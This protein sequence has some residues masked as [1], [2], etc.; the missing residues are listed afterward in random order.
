MGVSTGPMFADAT[1]EMSPVW[2]YIVGYDE[3]VGTLRLPI[4]RL[5]F[6]I[7][8]GGDN[9]L[10]LASD[11]A[12]SR[13]HCVIRALGAVLEIEDLGSSN[14]TQLNGRLISGKTL[15]PL[16][17][18]VVVGSTHLAVV[19]LTDAESGADSQGLTAA[20]YAVD[21]TSSGLIVPSASA[22]SERTEAL[23]VV[24]IVGSTLLLQQ[25]EL[26]V[27]QGALAVGQMLGRA[28]GPE[29]D[30][31]LQ[32]TGDGYLAC[33][34]TADRALA[35]AESVGSAASRHLTS[36]QLSTALHWGSAQRAHNGQRTGQA[37]H[38]AFALEKVRHDVPELEADFAERRVAQAIVMTEEFLSRLPPPQREQAHL[39][40]TFA[41][42][43]LSEPTRVYHWR[44]VVPS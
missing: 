15:V 29:D 7:G 26:A 5:P 11:P 1:S 13:H 43:G 16:P 3:A 21:A 35:A 12:I 36:V 30:S 27:A 44:S 9:L 23:L 22:F 41:L 38:A 40:G 33:F 4:E 8:R 39:L 20:L 37:V 14:G 2:A 31:Y 6:T 18:W 19:P 24:D 42:K 28:L 17:S 32:Y 34:S 25:D 10:C